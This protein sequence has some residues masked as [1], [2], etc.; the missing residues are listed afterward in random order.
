M[1]VSKTSTHSNTL[2]WYAWHHDASGNWLLL[3]GLQVLGRPSTLFEAS[4]VWASV[5]MTGLMTGFIFMTLLMSDGLVFM[6]DCLAV[7]IESSGETARGTTTRQPLPLGPSTVHY[8]TVQ[9]STVLHATLLQGQSK[10]RMIGTPGP[11]CSIS[12]SNCD[13]TPSQSKSLRLRGFG[14]R[15]EDRD[16][17][18]M[19]P[20]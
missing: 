13:E 20:R 19:R 12:A 18:Y 4:T 6:S 2:A 16:G 14:F 10:H 1:N 15:F 5:V 9:N 11:T 8:S 3:R 7:Y 17:A